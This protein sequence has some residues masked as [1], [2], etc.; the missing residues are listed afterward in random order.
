[1]GASSGS[2]IPYT[3][4]VPMPSSTNAALATTT[5]AVADGYPTNTGMIGQNS[6]GNPSATA[7]MGSSSSSSAGAAMPTGAIGAAALFGGA[8]WVANW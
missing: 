3:S 1:M 7:A 4:N 2:E 8:A 5:N 6:A